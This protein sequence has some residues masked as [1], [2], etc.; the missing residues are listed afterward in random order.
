MKLLMFYKASPDSFKSN[1][2]CELNAPVD[3][4]H[5]RADSRELPDPA[6]IVRRSAE[7]N[8]QDRASQASNVAAP[9]SQYRAGLSLSPRAPFER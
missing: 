9:P 1:P 5:E 2:P 6:T 4:P 8:S 3:G 7:A